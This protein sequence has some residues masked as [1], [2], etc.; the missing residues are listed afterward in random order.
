V[1]VESVIRVAIAA[2]GASLALFARS[3]IG[4]FIAHTPGRAL[5]AAIAVVLAFGTS[6]LI[7]RH[8]HLRAAMEES[9]VIEPSRHQDP[10][11]GWLFVPARTGHHSIGGRVVEYAFDGAGYRVR[12][13]QE[14]VDP[15]LP[16]V[17]FT[18][19]SMMVGEG[20]TWEETVPAQTGAMMGL[21]SAN[22][23]V[24]GF[25]NDQAYLRLQ[26]ELPHFRRPVAV[27][28]VFAPSL[29]DRNLDDDRPHL[30]PGLVWLPP[31]KRWRLAAIGQL[32]VRYRS[33]ETI[34]RG[35][36]VTREVLRA[37]VDL[38]RIRGAI[39]L[40]VVPQFG[41]EE[42]REQALRSRIL[43]DAGVPYVRVEL[44]PNW[45]IPGDGHP[46]PRAAH[47][48]AV[49]IAAGL[50]DPNQQPQAQSLGVACGTGDRLR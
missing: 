37:T 33:L 19:E 12:R 21:Q 40:I 41:A 32:L 47:T 1:L 8:L 23:A 30:G 27:V 49:A 4:R 50:R 31:E 24:S 38:A 18:G 11:L 6:E 14:P 28:S 17:L 13:I 34:E 42:P 7:L 48:I 43:D 45:R 2:L 25:A 22:L 35:V 20:L 5:L 16:T 26:A 9:A 36:T 15:Q 46:D 39:P 29:F 3:R 10:R 44:D